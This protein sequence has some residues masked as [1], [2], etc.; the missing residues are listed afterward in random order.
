MTIG[1]DTTEEEVDATEL[2]NL[3]LIVSALSSEVGCISIED[4]DVFFWTVN[5]I[6]QVGEHERVVALGVLHGQTYILV[7]IEGNDVLERYPTLLIS[8]YQAAIHTDG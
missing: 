2:L 3:L 7:H 8:F 5:V 6:E 4:M 1:A